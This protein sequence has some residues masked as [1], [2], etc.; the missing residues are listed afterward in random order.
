MLKDYYAINNGF[1]RLR[2]C[3]QPQVKSA[4]MEELKYTTDQ[5][6]GNVLRGTKKLYA[7]EWDAIEMIF[8]K[9]GV[10][11]PWGTQVKQNC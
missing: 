6:F 7:H 3:D 1:E 4:I 9:Y 2:A 11:D 8:A 10:V 5:A